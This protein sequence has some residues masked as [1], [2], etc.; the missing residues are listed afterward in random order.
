MTSIGDPAI[1]CQLSS[2]PASFLLTSGD[3][4]V[5][6]I[7]PIVFVSDH[8]D[9]ESATIT[10]TRSVSSRNIRSSGCASCL[11]S[12]DFMAANEK[13]EKRVA[14]QRLLRIFGLSHSQV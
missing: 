4:R 5:K 7:E 14:S 3:N 13:Q 11:N 1:S 12:C 8:V 6:I 2:H 10:L 9:S